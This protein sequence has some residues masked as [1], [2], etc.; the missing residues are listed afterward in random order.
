MFDRI[1]VSLF[2]RIMDAANARVD[3][4]VVDELVI[5]KW[6]DKGLVFL[7][8]LAERLLPFLGIGELFQKL[9]L[10]L[11]ELRLYSQTL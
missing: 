11:F 3:A 10:Q 7:Q 6:P 5:L 2:A 4:S 9:R 1:A 8:P